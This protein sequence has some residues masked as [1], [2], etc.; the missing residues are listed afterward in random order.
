M[1]SQWLWPGFKKRYLTKESRIVKTSCYNCS[2]LMRNESYFEYVL[3]K[4]DAL[5]LRQKTHEVTAESVNLQCQRDLRD[6]FAD[7]NKLNG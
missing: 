6:E 7:T 4:C 1:K 2:E 3:I 5:Q